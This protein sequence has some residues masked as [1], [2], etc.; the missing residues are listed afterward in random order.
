MRKGKSVRHAVRSHIGRERK[1]NEDAFACAP[2][3]GLYVIADGMGG[4]A[5]GEVASR[6]AADKVLSSVVARCD[7][8]FN[9]DVPCG[10][11]MLRQAVDRAQDE[12]RAENEDD[13][14]SEPMGTTV[15]AVLV[16]DGKADYVHVGDSRIYL[17][18][19]AGRIEQLT[20]DQTVAQR[21]IESGE[22]P[23]QAIE[24]YGHVL[25]GYAGKPEPAQPEIGAR[26]LTAGD[27]LL[28]CT[29]GLTDMVSDTEIA[30]IFARHPSA[31]D[32]AAEALIERAND[33]GGH[34]NITVIVI[35]AEE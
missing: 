32:A 8:V 6:M 34:D 1:N 28:L 16:A 13:P 31:P 4:L 9:T 15:A 11:D 14:D 2:D 7:P 27:T 10:A 24:H 3:L 17:V 22:D 21:K 29:D 26:D 23:V 30:E 18:S 25:T 5:R 33:N 35:L 12:V 19:R 20:T